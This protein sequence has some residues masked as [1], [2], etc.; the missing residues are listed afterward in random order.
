MSNLKVL[1]NE[2]VP[3]YETSTGEKVVYGSELYGVL[4]V[5]SNY[6]DWIKNRLNDCE[7]V[8]N[9]DYESFAKNLAKGGRPQID[10]I[11]KL[12]TAKEMAMLERN[13]KGKQVRRYFIQ[14][15]KKYKE[16]H[17]ANDCSLTNNDYMELLKIISTCDAERFQYV[18]SIL[19]A[20]G[21]SSY[22]R[23]SEQDCV[24]RNICN[25]KTCTNSKDVADFL[26]SVTVADTPTN[27]VYLQ[28]LD[29]C[30]MNNIEPVSKIA[31]SKAVNKILGTHVTQ[32]KINKVNRKVFRY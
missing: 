15:E 14:V 23:E 12:D 25:T 7:A 29:Y 24:N 13:E 26:Q 1:E 28:Y 11:I 5:K 8:E 18:V 2:L 21:F 27:D 31:F 10:H 9:E 30:S 3:V 16:Q 4:G 22:A 20:M 19:N 17:S 32:K 6:R